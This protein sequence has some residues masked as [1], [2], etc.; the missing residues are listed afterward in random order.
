MPK[1]VIPLVNSLLRGGVADKLTNDV[2][3]SANKAVSVSEWH[4]ATFVSEKFSSDWLFGSTEVDS[5][6]YYMGCGGSIVP[7]L[8]N[9]KHS[10]NYVC[11]LYYSIPLNKLTAFFSPDE[12]NRETLIIEINNN[13]QELQYQRN[14]FDAGEFVSTKGK[15]FDLPKNQKE[16]KK[17]YT[18][19]YKFI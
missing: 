11:A 3:F 15:I 16:N 17:T 10:A 12:H 14:R 7:D 8:W 4:T 5:I 2:T 9:C 19:K 6:G 1:K 13:I 18:I